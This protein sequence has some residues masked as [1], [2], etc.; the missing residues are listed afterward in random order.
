MV[1]RRTISLPG[2]LDARLERL[3][4]RINVSRVCATA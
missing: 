3:Q 2:E 1:Q 4:D